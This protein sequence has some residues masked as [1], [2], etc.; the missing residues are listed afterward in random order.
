MVLGV[1]SWSDSGLGFLGSG[2]GRPGF[3]DSRAKNI[4]VS[5]TAN[6]G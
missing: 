6:Y 4:L 1:E 5:T 3:T 2:I